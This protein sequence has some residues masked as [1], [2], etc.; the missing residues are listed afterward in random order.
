MVINMEDFLRVTADE[1]IPLRDVVFKTLRKAILRGDLQPGERLM[2][3]HLA[4]RMG[5]SRTPIREAIRMLELE[6]LVTMIPRR[7]ATV[8]E[9]TI[10]GMQDVLEV[11]S[12]LDRLAIELACDRITDE[13]LATLKDAKLCFEANIKKGDVVA[14]ADADVRFH[15]IIVSAAKNERLVQ[16]FNNLSEQVYRYRYEC[17]KNTAVHKALVHEHDEIYLSLLHKDKEK[18]IAT[19]MTHI[20]KQEESI[21]EKLHLEQQ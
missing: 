13:E 12:A 16:M 15:D 11:R 17:V 3:I 6:G 18:A 7:G 9:I 2:E 19:V 10:G 4:E 21:I 20:A 5:V 1:Y 14:I 8:A